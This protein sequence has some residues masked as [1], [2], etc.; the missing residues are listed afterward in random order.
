MSMYVERQ[1]LSS[2]ADPNLSTF[3]AC[4]NLGVVGQISLIDIKSVPYV[5]NITDLTPN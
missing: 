3:G 4:E 1:N 5:E 2:E